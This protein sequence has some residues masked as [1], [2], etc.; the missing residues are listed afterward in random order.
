MA[1][2]YKKIQNKLHP[3]EAEQGKTDL[4][5]KASRDALLLVL[6]ALTL[7]I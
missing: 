4:K 5:P 2:Q 3:K 7:V 6:I 1:T